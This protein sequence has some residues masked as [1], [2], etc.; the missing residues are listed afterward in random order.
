MDISGA[1]EMCQWLRGLLLLLWRSWVWLL[2]RIC[3]LTTI[4]NSSSGALTDLLWF[5]RARDPHAYT[6]V[7]MHH[8]YKAK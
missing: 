6:R 1:R 7:L 8:V 3:W 2:A 4:C 5:L